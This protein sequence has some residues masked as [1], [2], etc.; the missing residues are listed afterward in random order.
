LCTPELKFCVQ[1]VHKKYWGMCFQRNNKFWWLYFIT[2]GTV[3][4]G[5]NR[6]RENEKLLFAGP[7]TRTYTRLIVHNVSD[8]AFEITRIEFIWLLCVGYIARLNLCEQFMFLCKN[9]RWYSKRN[10]LI[11]QNK[12]CFVL[13]NILRGCLWLESGGQHLNTHLCR[14]ASWNA[15]KRLEIPI[16]SK[17]KSTAQ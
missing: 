17:C 12:L 13:R 7:C 4:L 2:S 9:W 6:R 11:Y 5:L 8:V 16:P 1:W 15:G 10:M 3:H 14:N